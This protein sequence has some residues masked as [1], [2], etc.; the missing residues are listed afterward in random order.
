MGAE[1]PA[2]TGPGPRLSTLSLGQG[3]PNPEHSFGFLSAKC[4][5]SGLAMSAQ[6]PRK[7]PGLAKSVPALTSAAKSG[8]SPRPVRAKVRTMSSLSPDK[9]RAKSAFR[10]Q[11]GNRTSASWPVMSAESSRRWT[12]GV[13]NLGGCTWPLQVR[14]VSLLWPG[15][16]RAKSR[17]VSAHRPRHGS[18][19]S[20]QCPQSV[21]LDSRPSP[22]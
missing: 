17:A 20:G 4:P 14:A 10:P 19:M 7:V 9:G 2:D 12:R 11:T 5:H 15:H 21:R 6:S 1:T 18:K 16:V 8:N 22:P 3:M 13:R